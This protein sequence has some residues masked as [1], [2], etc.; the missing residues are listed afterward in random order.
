PLSDASIRGRSTI[1]FLRFSEAGGLSFSEGFDMKGLVELVEL[2][3]GVCNGEAS[4]Y[5]EHRTARLGQLRGID[6]LEPND[7]VTW[8]WIDDGPAGE[9]YESA[10]FDLESAA[11]ARRDM[12][13]A[14]EDAMELAGAGSAVE[15]DIARTVSESVVQLSE[16]GFDN[17]MQL[18]ERPEFDVFTVQHSL[19]VSLLATYVASQLGASKEMVIEIGAAAM[20]HDVGKGRIPAEILYKPGRLSEDERRLI[21][22]HPQLGTE[23]LLESPDVSACVLGAA[24]GHHLRYD[25]KGYPERRPWF[26]TTQITSLIQVCDVFEA[27]TARRPYKA[28]YSP[29]RAFQILFADAGAFDP[30]VL[31]SFTR[32]MGLFPPGRFVLLSDGRL[33]RVARAGEALDRPSIRLFP[34]GEMLDLGA[35]SNAS[36]SVKRLLDE[37]EFV[38]L[39]MGAKDGVVVEA[40]EAP[41]PSEAEEEAAAAEKARDEELS[42]TMQ[43]GCD[44]G[45]DCRLC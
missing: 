24:W 38:E 23:I 6:L 31:S 13:S 10:G 36:F 33:G 26:E 37:P 1:A 35:P 27:L 22:T 12:A 43:D 39:L 41:L 45:D 8:D 20:F 16:T 25:G 5:G 28:P 3:R 34:N 44:H 9:A 7:D 14:V 21:T 2:A 42:A 19:R 29:A 40:P 17:I 18:A 11:P 4:A 30:A 15:L 32:A